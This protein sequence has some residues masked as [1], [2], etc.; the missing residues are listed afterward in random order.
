M[1]ERINCWIADYEDTSLLEESVG[2]ENVKNYLL[3]EAMEIFY[4]LKEEE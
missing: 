4:K 2:A 3:N 1:K